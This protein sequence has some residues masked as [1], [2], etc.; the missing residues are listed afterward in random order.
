MLALLWLLS[1]FVRASMIAIVTKALIWKARME[2]GVWS[3]EYG[4]WSMEYGVWKNL[5]F[6]KVSNN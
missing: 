4:V 3:M 2:R 1:H 6:D 5:N